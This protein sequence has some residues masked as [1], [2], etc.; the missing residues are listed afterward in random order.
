[1][2]ERSQRI[3]VWWALLGTVVYGCCMFFLWHMLPPP[4][5]QWPAERIAQFYQEHSTQVRVGAMIAGWLS[6]FFL[7]LAVVIAVQMRRI[8][9]RPVWA[10]MALAAGAL[11]TVYLTLPPLFWGVAAF[12][13]TRNP[14]ITATFHEFGVL[15]VI[16]TDQYFVFLWVAIVVVCLTPT[17]VVASPF[18]R[19]FGYFS[20]WCAL[21]FEC[22]AVAFL[23]RSGPFAWN[24]LL[25]FWL[26]FSVFGVW[27]IVVSVLLLRA[28]RQQSDEDLPVE[29][30]F[31]D[32]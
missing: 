31:V 10:M 26:P 6:G 1:M 25:A 5:P 16:T 30:E 29:N 12:T 15:S 4:S 3:L 17:K 13:P 8:E 24:G 20:A 7:A 27:M 11:T 22:G 19:W 2:S 21:I 32:A 14:E 18:P 9:R 23:P 28:L